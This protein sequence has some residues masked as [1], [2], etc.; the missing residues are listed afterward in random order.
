MIELFKPVNYKP[1]KDCDCGSGWSS[2]LV[3]NTIY[4]LD[5][6]PACCIHDYMYSVGTNI[7]HKDSA[8]RTFLNNMMRIIEDKKAWWFPHFLARQRAL[9]YYEAVHNFGGTSFWQGKNK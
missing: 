6:K 7:G 9:K 3:P 8:D 4:G 2:K 1:E 5:I